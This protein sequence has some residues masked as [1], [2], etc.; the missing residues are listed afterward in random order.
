MASF[1]RTIFPTIAL[2]FELNNPCVI[3]KVRYFYE[4]RVT[5][6]PTKKVARTQSMRGEYPISKCH[7]AFKILI[8]ARKKRKK[9][10][11]W[12]DS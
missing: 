6:I 11:I 5:V 7:S 4:I 1:S 8:R 12:L 10:P 3:A 9:V 2:F